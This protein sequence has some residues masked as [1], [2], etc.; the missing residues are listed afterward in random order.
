M[1]KEFA[2]DWIGIT[3]VIFSATS[4]AFY[5]VLFK[6]FN[7]HGTLGQVSLFM[8]FLGL[9]DLFLNV[10]PSVVLVLFDVDHIDWSY[11]PWAALAG[12]ALLGLIYNFL[13]NFGIALLNPL[14]I[15]IG[16]LCGE[17]YY[18]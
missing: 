13:V 11:V 1:D 18:Y 7:G 15:S 3:L 17:F 5:K 12:S 10:I 9:M 2:G 16:M 8:S 14:V 4:A 6:K